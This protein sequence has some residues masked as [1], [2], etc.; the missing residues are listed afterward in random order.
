MSLP[1]LKHVKTS[2]QAVESIGVP[3]NGG[4]EEFKLALVENG[5]RSLQG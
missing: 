1:P 2:E 3:S 5:S 4:F